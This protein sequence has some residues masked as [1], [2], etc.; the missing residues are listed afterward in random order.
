MSRRDFVVPSQLWAS[1]SVVRLRLQSL[2]FYFHLVLS[3]ILQIKDSL[4]PKSSFFLG[5]GGR[6]IACQE[7]ACSTAKQANQTPQLLYSSRS[8]SA[9][10][11]DA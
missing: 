10:A 7:V 8:K 2:I 5:V 11:L 4:K 1:C 9:I 6:D 3:A